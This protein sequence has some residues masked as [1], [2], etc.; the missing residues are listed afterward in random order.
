M[1]VVSA[2]CKLVDARPVR[3]VQA[4]IDRSFFAEDRKDAGAINREFVDW[5]SQRPEPA[6][7]FFVFLNYLDAHS[8]YVLP[9]GAEHRFGLKPQSRSD[10]QVI[11]D[12]WNS[13]DKLRLSP[14]VRALV[15]DSYDNC[16]AHLDVGLGSLFDEL[17]RHGV[18]DRTLVIVTSDHGE[19]LGEHGL[20]DHGESLYRTE[21]RV[22]LVIV[23]PAALRTRGVLRQ[24]V[25]LRDLPATIVELAGQGTG[26]PFPGRTLSRLWT[27]PTI[28]KD[29]VAGELVVS[30]LSAPNPHNPNQGRSPASR[31]PLVAIAEHDFVYIQNAG[32]GNE[33]LYNERDDPD[34]RINRAR[35]AAF[36][37]LLEQFHSRL[38]QWKGRLR[39]AE[40]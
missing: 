30:E 3:T 32:D 6:R 26:S 24:P 22:P 19:G 11:N 7:P 36:Q 2:L 33:E 13:I 9:P 37:P 15:R 18:L 25:S 16:V 17:E 5:L 38:A 23:P 35:A 8:P 28:G 29:S 27:D 40:R 12:H 10:L 31:G 20:F 1:K 39:E 21:V 4:V 34:E 14:R